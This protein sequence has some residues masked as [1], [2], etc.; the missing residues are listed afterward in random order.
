[1]VA[2]LCQGSNRTNPLCNTSRWLAAPRIRSRIAAP[3][4]TAYSLGHCLSSF[5]GAFAV[6]IIPVPAQFRQG[7][8]LPDGCFTHPLPLQIVQVCFAVINFSQPTI[9]V[10]HQRKRTAN[11]RR[12]FLGFKI[13][14][15]KIH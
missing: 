3:P 2:N 8:S 4:V 1:M 5:I 7:I 6:S 9:Q 13:H 14:F 12:P 15:L 10:L 11:P